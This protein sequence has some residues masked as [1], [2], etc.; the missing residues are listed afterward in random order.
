M[1]SFNVTLCCC[2]GLL[3]G[4]AIFTGC[5]S[6][7][8][9][10]DET[11]QR[12]TANIAIQDLNAETLTVD[13]I[14]DFCDSEAEDYGPASAAVDFAV[15]PN[16]P[17]ITLTGYTLEYIPLPSEDGTGTIVMPPPLDSPL[18][19]GNLGIDIASAG[20]A[21]FE[22]TCMSV[23]TKEEYRRKVGWTLYTETPEGLADIAAKQAEVDAKQ[24]EVDATLAA[25]ASAPDGS[26]TSGLQAVLAVQQAQL[27][28]LQAELDALFFSFRPPFPELDEAR[29]RI[30]I[31]FFF[32]DTSG[33][34]RTVVRDATV[35]LGNFD[36]C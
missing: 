35:W 31:T 10:L 21:S 4:L 36:N 5:G 6:D 23:D 28:Q 20:T 17:G 30:R 33:E 8:D 2:I 14:Q 19:G 32:E 26:D 13:V 16:A 7:T 9:L 34:D 1:R 18:P 11:G 22:I 15:D 27:E 12:Y 25:I 3:A 29:Y 24:A